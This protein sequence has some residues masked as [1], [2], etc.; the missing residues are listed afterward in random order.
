MGNDTAKLAD[1][2]AAQAARHRFTRASV[3]WRVAGEAVFVTVTVW[4]VRGVALGD[5]PHVGVV[6]VRAR[7]VDRPYS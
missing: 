4:P 7:R 1:R 6:R 3:A 2:A 5:V